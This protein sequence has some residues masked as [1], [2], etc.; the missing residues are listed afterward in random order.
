MYPI[1]EHA[2]KKTSTR[3]GFNKATMI[4]EFPPS[5][6]ARIS[7]EETR[8]GWR[9]GIGHRL[10]KCEVWGSHCGLW[11]T[12]EELEMEREIG[13]FPGSRRRWSKRGFRL[14]TT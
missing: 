5:A 12:F 7:Q 9:S 1:S 14:A 10:M 3:E 4:Q 11:T 2:E 13:S 8:A 6:P